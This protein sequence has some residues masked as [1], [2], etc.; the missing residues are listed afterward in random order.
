[1]E[2]TLKLMHVNRLIRTAVK[3]V[4]GV[5]LR[6]TGNSFEI[7][8][9]SGILWFK[10]G[11][12][13]DHAWGLHCSYVHFTTVLKPLCSLS[14]ANFFLCHCPLAQQLCPCGSGGY[15]FHFLLHVVS[16][17][18]LYALPVL[19]SVSFDTRLHWSSDMLCLC[20]CNKGTMLLLSLLHVQCSQ[21]T[22]GDANSAMQIKEQYPLTG[23]VRQF[24]RRDL[25]KGMTP[26]L[27]S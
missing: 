4:K 26:L 21:G 15:E 5:E 27:S 3:L 9:L 1:M 12:V 17:Q 6:Q 8:V 20:G 18:L 10:V 7:I 22:K 14:A 11:T 23:E 19:R 25:R 13:I 16:L 24:K 2:P